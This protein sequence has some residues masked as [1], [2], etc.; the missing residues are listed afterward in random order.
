MPLEK[1]LQWIYASAM[2]PTIEEKQEGERETER[3]ERKLERERMRARKVEKEKLRKGKRGRFRCLVEIKP[4][5]KLTNR[6][7]HQKM[8]QRGKDEKNILFP[9]TC[10][11]GVFLLRPSQ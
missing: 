10:F 2:G 9:R 8:S 4:Q 3:Q 7:K 6:S 1:K 11:N 5:H